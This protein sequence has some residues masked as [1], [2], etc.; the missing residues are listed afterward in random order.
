MSRVLIY[1]ASVWQWKAPSTLLVEDEDLGHIRHSCLVTIENGFFA[2]V[3]EWSGATPSFEG[4]DTVIDAR[5]QLLLPGL[6]DAH[7]HVAM[8]GES[9]Y[10]VH[11]QHCESLQQL[12]DTLSQH[13][14]AHPELPWVTGVNW[15]QTKLGS[16]PSRHDI[17]AVGSKPIF[18]WRTCW[19]IGVANTAAL[20]AAGLVRGEDEA[21]GGGISSMVSGHGKWNS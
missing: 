2:S 13:C 19:H 4:Y 14:A 5:Q 17:D 18:L 21:E 20:R 9:Q 1:N 8:L 12:R 10:F 15:D 16:Y 3:S 7:I 11:L 6:I